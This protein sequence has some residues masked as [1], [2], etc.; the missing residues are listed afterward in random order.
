MRIRLMQIDVG[1]LMD[2]G[3]EPLRSG[4]ARSHHHLPFPPVGD[5]VGLSE[6]FDVGDLQGEACFGDEFGHLPP[7]SGQIPLDEGGSDF[8]KRLAVGLGKVEDVDHPEADH[9]SFLLAVGDLDLSY[10]RS[11]DR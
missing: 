9:P 2:R 11:K 6:P 10:D 8:G 4:Q 7:L 3:L 1:Q 5:A